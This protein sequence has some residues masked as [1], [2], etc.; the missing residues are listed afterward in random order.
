M[1]Q[2]F[3]FKIVKSRKIRKKQESTGDSLVLFAI[4]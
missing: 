3:M 1:V 2:T 4:L